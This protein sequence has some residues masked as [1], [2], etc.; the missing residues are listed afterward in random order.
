MIEQYIGNS[1]FE[2]LQRLLEG[3]S[4]SGRALAENLE[5]NPICSVSYDGSIP[6]LLVRWRG[7]ATST[8]IRYI[9]E[10][11]IQLLGRH[12][13]SKILG[14]D[15][16]LVS[17]SAI[18]QHWIV[19]DWMPRAMAAGLKAAASV[20]PRGYFGQTAVNRI[21]PFVPAG[22]AVQSFESAEQAR[23]WLR[24][25]H[26]PGH[27]RI[28]Y[29]RFKGGEP[30]NVFAFW[31]HDPSTGYF[32]QVARVALRSFWKVEGRSLE[33]FMSRQ[34]LPELIVIETEAGEEVC[35]WS[36]QDEIRQLETAD[37]SA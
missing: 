1:S 15:S 31:C 20:K 36:L 26:Q 13:T 33:P 28:L 11:L 3:E 35:R 19:R 16:D 9:L 25:V 22:L 21:L 29:R 17:I 27:Y 32:R 10:S 2:S 24:T 6:C 14:D 23:D 7:Y 5:D 37:K 12:R 30:L 8:Q 34:P 4:G 18:D